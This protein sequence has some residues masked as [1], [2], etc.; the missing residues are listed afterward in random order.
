MSCVG[1]QRARVRN[2]SG[3]L[4]VAE[5]AKRLGFRVYISLSGDGVPL[6]FIRRVPLSVKC[7]MDRVLK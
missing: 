5:W 1:R 7:W 4:V 2:L 3:S 6:L